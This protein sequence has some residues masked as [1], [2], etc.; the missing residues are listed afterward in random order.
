MKGIFMA[1]LPLPLA[2]S[3]GH[4][5]GFTLD[6]G[7]VSQDDR[8]VLAGR[9]AP[10]AACFRCLLAKQDR[11]LSRHMHRVVSGPLDTLASPISRR[12]P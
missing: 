2:A 10:E 1:A 4:G 6:D 7:Q 11:M 9:F 12:S 3:R 5:A 8:Q